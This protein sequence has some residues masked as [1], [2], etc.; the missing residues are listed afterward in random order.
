MIP[1]YLMLG[2]FTRD[3]LPDGTITPGGTAF[4]AA[5]TV[6]RLS[7]QVAVVSAPADLPADWPDSSVGLPARIVAANLRRSLYRAGPRADPAYR[8]GRPDA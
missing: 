3:L 5:R 8:L 6:D 2:H 4:Y 7:R 1:D